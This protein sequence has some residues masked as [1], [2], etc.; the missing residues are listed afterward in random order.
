MP[1]AL[2]PWAL[3]RLAATRLPIRWRWA[4]AL[5]VFGYGG[6]AALALAYNWG[7]N[8]RFAP[9]A[10]ILVGAAVAVAAALLSWTARG[11][12][13]DAPVRVSLVAVAFWFAAI[14]I[15]LPLSTLEAPRKIAGARAAFVGP[16]LEAARGQLDFDGDGYA[17]ALGG[18]DCDDRDPLIHPGAVDI[19]GDGADADCDGEDATDALPPPARMVDLPHYGPPEPRPAAR[20]DRH[21]ARRSHRRLRVPAPD[22]ARDRRARR[23]RDAVR[24]RL[25]ARAVDPLFDAGDRRRP[26]AVGDHVGR[27]DLVAP[28]RPRRAHD[29]AGAC[30]TRATSPAACSASTTSRR[31]IGAASSAAWTSTTP[32]AR[33]CTSRSTGRWSRADRRRAKSPTTRSRSSTGIATRSSSSGFTTTIRTSSYETHPEVPSFGASRVDRYDGEIR[34]TDLHLGRLIAH[35]RAAGLWDRTAVVLTGD[36]GE[37]FGEHGVTEHGFDLYPAQT[38]VPFIVRVPGIAPRRVRVPVGHVDIAP[39]VAEPGARRRRAGVHRAL[40]DPGH[41]RSARARH[42]HARRVPGGDLGA[43]EEARAGDDGAAPGVERGAGRHD[44]VLRPRAR[45]GRGARHLAAG[46]RRRVRGAGAL[47]Q[48]DGRRA[49]PAA[50]RRGQARAGGHAAGPRRAA[51]RAPACRPRWET[52][53]LVRGYDACSPAK[54]PRVG[55]WTSRITSRWASRSLPAGGCSFTWK[56]RPATATWTTSRSTA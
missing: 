2:L 40:A 3:V 46:R 26:L 22:V 9:W 53:S 51:A 38:K 14:G 28:A 55:R 49:R 23:G 50:R 16:T 7:D 47:A 12:L 1:A 37:G 35:L 15:V 27:V 33:R 41:R 45:S 18:G 54:F 36:H 8:L 52:P 5:A 31:P 11:R 13:P 34:F 4:V 21:A 30:T 43:R 44:R 39:D 32:S 56:G 42:R 48:A 24:E 6:A 29:R 19:P 17:R 10:E 20:H 25:G